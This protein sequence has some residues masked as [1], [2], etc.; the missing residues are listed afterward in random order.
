M[1]FALITFSLSCKRRS[2]LSVCRYEDINDSRP[3]RPLEKCGTFLTERQAYLFAVLTQFNE[4]D[5]L[6][7]ELADSGISKLAD[8]KSLSDKALHEQFDRW[9]DHSREDAEKED[10]QYATFKIERMEPPRSPSELIA[11]LNEDE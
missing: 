2:W 5:K 3:R 9:N 6:F 11:M 7:T 4:N 8:I 10:E 1:L